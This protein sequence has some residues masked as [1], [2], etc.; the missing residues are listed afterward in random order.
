MKLLCSSSDLGFM[1][2]LEVAL[3][4][5]GIE[6]YTSDADRVMAGIAG[7]MGSAG[8][9]YILDEA[10]WDKAVGVMNNLAQPKQ[11]NESPKSPIKKPIPA[12]AIAGI[13]IFIFFGLAVA[14]SK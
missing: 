5:E 12:W 9:I 14:L 2:S 4:A 10:D 8:R 7:P 11:A 13:V 6:T 1:F 3:N